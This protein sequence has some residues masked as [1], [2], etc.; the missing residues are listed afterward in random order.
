MDEEHLAI[1]ALF[2][3]AAIGFLCALNE[4]IRLRAEGDDGAKNVL[5][6]SS[7]KHELQ[8]AIHWRN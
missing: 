5:G 4:E 8:N 2:I 7:L 6:I 1:S 3:D